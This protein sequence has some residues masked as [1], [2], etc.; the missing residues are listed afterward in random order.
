[1]L[2]DLSSFEALAGEAFEAHRFVRPLLVS[3]LAIDVTK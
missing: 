3:V 2:F 1:L